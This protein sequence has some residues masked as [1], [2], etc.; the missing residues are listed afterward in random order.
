M[1]GQMLVPASQIFAK[2]FIS[3]LFLPSVHLLF[4]HLSTLTVPPHRPWR[5]SC[6]SPTHP[7][8]PVSLPTPAGP[9]VAVAASAV[10]AVVAV[11]VPLHPR[12]LCTVGFL[13]GRLCR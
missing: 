1:E 3:F 12:F 11:A 7:A 4:C 9:I 10:A 8:G 5:M 13:T 6:Q 2:L